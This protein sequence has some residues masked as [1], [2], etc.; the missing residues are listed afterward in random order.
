MN[1]ETLVDYSE[2]SF[3][4]KNTLSHFKFRIIENSILFNVKYFF[5]D[6]VLY[7]SSEMTEYV[8]L[9]ITRFY[10]SEVY[11]INVFKIAFTN[12]LATRLK[13]FFEV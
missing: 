4:N 7:K 11:L 12:A 1:Y 9:L 3:K 8:R 10:C 5:E 2:I 6:V 13:I